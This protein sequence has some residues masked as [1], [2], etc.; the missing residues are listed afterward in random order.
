MLKEKSMCVHLH[1]SHEDVRDGEKKW[2]AIKGIKKKKKQSPQNCCFCEICIS[3]DQLISFVECLPQAWFPFLSH[4]LVQT[5][6]GD[7]MLPT[8][9]QTLLSQEGADGNISLPYFS[10]L[11]WPLKQLEHGAKND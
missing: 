6:N 3:H 8:F 2:K 5:P 11:H 10:G 9:T 1:N 7:H 4:S